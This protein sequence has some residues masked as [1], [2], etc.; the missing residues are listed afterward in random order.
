MALTITVEAD[1]DVLLTEKIL[2]IYQKYPGAPQR[3]IAD[4]VG[5]SQMHISI[6]LRTI[7]ELEM[8]KAKR[9]AA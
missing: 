9:S 8:I 6:A 4:A 5:C 3:V 2:S 1:E 7:R